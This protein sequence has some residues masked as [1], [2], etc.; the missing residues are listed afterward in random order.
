MTHR[1]STLSARPA[2]LMPGVPMLSG[3][4]ARRPYPRRQDPNA[5]WPRRYRPATPEETG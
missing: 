3:A 4:R 5:S 1:I 2:L